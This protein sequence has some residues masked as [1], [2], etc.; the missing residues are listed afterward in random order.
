VSADDADNRTIREQI[1]EAVLGTHFD[2]V[3]IIV[4]GRLPEG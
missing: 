3:P 4:A 1:L 2:Q